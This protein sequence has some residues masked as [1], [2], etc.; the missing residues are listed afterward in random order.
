M[1]KH[2]NPPTILAPQ[3]DHT[4]DGW[5]SVAEEPGRWWLLLHDS[6]VAEGEPGRYYIGRYTSEGYR[7]LSDRPCEPTHWHEMPDPVTLGTHR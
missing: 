7:D 4:V 6:E 5:H 3:I 2:R 1:N